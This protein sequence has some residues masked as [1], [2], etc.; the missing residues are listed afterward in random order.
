VQV[1]MFRLRMDDTCFRV[2]WVELYDMRFAV[3]DPHDTVI[4]AH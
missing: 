3:V 1:L 2:V 4:V